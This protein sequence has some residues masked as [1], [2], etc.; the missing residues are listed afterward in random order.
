MSEFDI[1]NDILDWNFMAGVSKEC[2]EQD[3]QE[4]LALIE[5]E[6]NELREAIE[7]NDRVAML[8][9]IG[10]III[11]CVGF[12]YRNN[13]D[14]SSALNEIMSSNWTKIVQLDGFDPTIDFEALEKK[15]KK[16]LKLVTGF[17]SDDTGKIGSIQ[18]ENNKV[19]KPIGYTPPSLEEYV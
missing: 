14:V 5:E 2:S 11:V 1:V 19:Q 7:N 9:A 13:M 3:I 4:A 8:D 15:G 10:D 16:G 12:C 17:D 6:V 18:D